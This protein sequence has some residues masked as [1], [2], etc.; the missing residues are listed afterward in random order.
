MNDTANTKRGIRPRDAASLVLIDDSA[1]EPRILMGRRH[2]RMKF[3]PDAFVFPGGKLDQGDIGVR[4][5]SGFAEATAEAVKRAA[6]SRAKAEALAAAAIRE[7][8]EETGLLIARQGDVGAAAGE[9]WTPFRERGLA[10]CLDVLDFVARAIT[11]ASSPIRFHARF[12]A[13]NAEAASGE[14]KGSGELEDLGWYTL[15]EALKL[16]VIDVT[17]FVLHEIARRHRGE[18]RA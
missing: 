4:P 2:S 17:E 9:G 16:P 6:A 8:F 13:A 1:G 12:F 15:S 10:P 18:R 7:T 5:A 14:L 3:I 11:P